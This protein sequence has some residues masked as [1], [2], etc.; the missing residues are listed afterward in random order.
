MALLLPVALLVRG[1]PPHLPKTAQGGGPGP[2]HKPYRVRD[3]HQHRVWPNFGLQSWTRV[4][5]RAR[6]PAATWAGCRRDHDCRCQRHAERDARPRPPLESH[7]SAQ[8]GMHLENGRQTQPAR[9]G[10]RRSDLLCTPARRRGLQAP[11]AAARSGAV[12]R[13]APWPGSVLKR[14]LWPRCRSRSAA[15]N[16]YH[17]DSHEDRTSVARKSSREKPG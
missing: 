5:A 13:A 15:R 16:G 9:R 3:R 7:V 2:T 11:R 10:S 12:E 17:A 8:G 4:P 1:T 14:G 6:G